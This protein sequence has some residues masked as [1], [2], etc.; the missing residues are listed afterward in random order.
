[1]PPKTREEA[2]ADP[3]FKALDAD[4]QA[5]VLS[6]LPSKAALTAR[7]S[8]AGEQ[9]LRE[10]VEGQTAAFRER[11]GQASIG[12][13]GTVG[14]MILQMLIQGPGDFSSS[15]LPAT[16]E[17]QLSRAKTRGQP[18]I[19]DMMMSTI[20]GM[21]GGARA[22][23]PGAMIGAGLG[24]A[25]G[26]LLRG[27]P[28]PQAL[29]E[30][31]EAALWQGGGDL[32]SRALLNFLRPGV[33]PQS[34]QLLQQ[35]MPGESVAAQIAAGP[36]ID[37]DKFGVGDLAQRVITMSRELESQVAGRAY[38]PV[39]SAIRQ[40][41]PMIDIT[42]I[43]QAAA[44]MNLALSDTGV[45]IVQRQI[46]AFTR[47]P[48]QIPVGQAPPPITTQTVVDPENA[49]RLRS[50]LLSQGRKLE[51]LGRAAGRNIERGASNRLAHMVDQ[52]IEDAADR[53]GVRQE[54]REANAGFREN[55]AGTFYAEAVDR[56]LETSPEQF[57]D[58]LLQANTTEARQIMGALRNAQGNL[59]PQGEE[60]QA[61]AIGSILSQATTKSRGVLSPARLANAWFSPQMDVS[62]RQAIWGQPFEQAFTEFVQHLNSAQ[63]RGE[64]AFILGGPVVVATAATGPIGSA[65]AGMGA[66]VET[67]NEF[68]IV[69]RLMLNRPNTM[70]VL[71]NAVIT[72][73]AEP[74]RRTG[75]GHLMHLVRV[76]G[77]QAEREALGGSPFIQLFQSSDATL[78]QKLGASQL[79]HRTAVP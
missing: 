43:E 57:V 7:G 68:G 34:Q 26:P 62:K 22:G 51:D 52:A 31:T 5:E 42:R 75:L 32:A 6:R 33:S 4:V 24:A 36:R 74:L 30:G 9:A 60:V 78:E 72:G 61:R 73:N 12:D 77:V 3:A 49:I 25:G 10:S 69:G 63:Y 39:V 64:L 41:E 28:V 20:G 17:E 44:R 66:G 27:E 21:A 16:E 71:A 54:W 35:G 18:S 29:A 38:R 14:K 53:A 15:P 79:P 11:L 55:V 65:G 23:V 67:M 13:V 47:P 70:R 2:F 19:D 56:V 48:G 45:E 50:N 40:V 1:M 58:E 59:F 46:P 8:Q 76:G 37:I